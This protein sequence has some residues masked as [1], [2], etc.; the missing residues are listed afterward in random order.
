MATHPQESPAERLARY[1][2]FAE[3]AAKSAIDAPDFETAK[4]FFKLA[5]EWERLA[6]GG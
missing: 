1:K 6:K 4:G 5:G 3:E 2:R